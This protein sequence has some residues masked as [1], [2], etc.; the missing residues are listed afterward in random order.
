M[1]NFLQG[2]KTAS[3]KD[4]LMSMKVARTST[5][6]KDVSQRHYFNEPDMLLKN[7]RPVESTQDEIKEVEDHGELINFKILL[8]RY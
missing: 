3:N 6:A 1:V 2:K 8:Q 4:V 7:F 5:S